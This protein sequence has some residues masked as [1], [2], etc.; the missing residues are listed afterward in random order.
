[1]SFVF[2]NFCS[3]LCALFSHEG[4][5]VNFHRTRSHASWEPSL[6]LSP[7]MHRSR[8]FLHRFVLIFGL[9]ALRQLP[10]GLTGPMFSGSLARFFPNLGCYGEKL[11][12][13]PNL[14]KLAAEG[15]R[16]NRMFTTAP[17]CSAS[18]SAF[19]TGMYQTTIGAHNHRSHRDDG[20]GLPE[21]V[22]RLTDLM[23]DAG[24]HTANLKNLPNPAGSKARP[25]LTG[26]SH[27]TASNSIPTGGMT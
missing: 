7:V 10:C 25:R 21:G 4:R 11:V 6:T 13:S 3:A 8:L 27:M 18:R 2:V 23:R 9:C 19:M 22:H 24:Y 26:I 20:Q 15:M 5:P 12:Q 14:D 17:V 1:M 16:Y